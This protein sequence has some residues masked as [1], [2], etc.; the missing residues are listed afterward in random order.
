MR[1]FGSHNQ[2]GLSEDWDVNA[3]INLRTLAIG[4][5]AR[6]NACGIPIIPQSEAMDV[7]AGTLKL[8]LQRKTEL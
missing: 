6:Q 7:E 5:V 8:R 2:H 1:H 4:S 3:A